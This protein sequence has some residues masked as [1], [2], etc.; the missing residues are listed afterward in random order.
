MG[1]HLASGLNFC[2]RDKQ[3]LTNMF[4]MVCPLEYPH[5]IQVINEYHLCML[6]LF[7]EKK[8][9]KITAYY[10]QA[11]NCSGQWTAVIFNPFI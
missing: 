3:K 8:Y 2:I 1:I 4:L 5:N 10:Y 7:L 11:K 9:T 6:I